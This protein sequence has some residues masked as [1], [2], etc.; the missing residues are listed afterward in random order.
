MS[1]ETTT[2]T[3]S[4]LRLGEWLFK[5]R[6]YTPVPL[7]IAAVIL[8]YVYD[9]R[10]NQASILAGA[11]FIVLG[12]LIRFWGVSYIGPVSRTRSRSTGNLQDSGPYSVVRNPLYVGNFFLSLGLVIV[13]NIWYLVPVYV[14]FFGFQYHYIVQWE[15]WNLRG[16]FGAEYATYCTQVPRWVPK[17]TQYRGGQHDFAKALKSERWT[18]L[19]IVTV[20]ALLAAVK[21]GLLHS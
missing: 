2:L 20:S 14:F 12:E 9:I 21:L 3:D 19:A 6:D 15:E 4:R 11:V 18:L 5:K 16:K 8:M 10:P 17:F 13:A 7:I 1:T